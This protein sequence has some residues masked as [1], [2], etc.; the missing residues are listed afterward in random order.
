[1]QMDPIADTVLNIISKCVE[2]T[3]AGDLHQVSEKFQ[4]SDYDHCSICLNELFECTGEDGGVVSVR[5]MKCPGRHKFHSQCLRSWL[6]RSKLG[7]CPI[8]RH[9]FYDSVREDC[10]ANL[11]HQIQ[12]CPNASFKCIWSKTYNQRVSAVKIIEICK[13]S[14][15]LPFSETIASAFLWSLSEQC[16]N[17]DDLDDDDIS[18]LVLPHIWDALEVLAPQSGWAYCASLVKAFDFALSGAS[19]N[20]IL[21]GIRA[22]STNEDYVVTLVS[23]GCFS[24][25]INCLKMSH[26]DWD[27]QCHEDSYLTDM[28]A[29]AMYN[30]VLHEELGPV[31]LRELLEAFKVA[32]AEHER[33]RFAIAISE[34]AHTNCDVLDMAGC[35]AL[36]SGGAC[37]ALIED[38]K[39]S[40]TICNHASLNSKKMDEFCHDV[41]FAI[42]TLASS[43]DE[44]PAVVDAFVD[45]SACDALVAALR[46]FRM[47][48]DVQHATC[49]MTPACNV[50][51]AMNSISQQHIG[52]VALVAA[53]AVPELIDVLKKAGPIIAGYQ[54]AETP[55]FSFHWN[56]QIQE[57]AVILSHLVKT[58]KGRGELIKSD[59]CG[60]L[61]EILQNPGVSLHEENLCSIMHYVVC[62]SCVDDGRMINALVEGLHVASN[63][64]ARSKFSFVIGRL[65]RSSLDPNP[66]HFITSGSCCA[67]VQAF[68]MADDNGVRTDIVDAIYILLKNVRDSRA[69]LVAAGALGVLKESLEMGFCSSKVCAIADVIFVLSE[70]EKGPPPL[71]CVMHHTSSH[72]ITHLICSVS[73]DAFLVPA[74]SLVTSAQPRSMPRFLE[75]YA[76]LNAPGVVTS[77]PLSFNQ[78]KI[79][80][81]KRLDIEADDAVFTE[82]KQALKYAYVAVYT[83]V[84]RSDVSSSHWP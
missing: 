78:L 15:D 79:E 41:T 65:A 60:A 83:K 21:H 38:L 25:L 18:A 73:L 20:L 14:S 50:L 58:K 57:T 11:D 43:L 68:K 23:L 82:N 35:I 16:D 63:D 52:R 53:D 29:Y 55:D 30:F 9:N 24:I 62:I 36:I 10:E 13:S 3:I 81:A 22:V 64:Y 4:D 42:F 31:L 34:I 75:M 59:A 66:V 33:Q 74:E 7:D 46:I 56:E 47:N 1:M 61:I 37:T 49:D 54:I 51:N 6:A 67:L 76:A 70:P 2:A 44:C 80:I 39:K 77:N 32:D 45:A 72:I 12:P 71:Q 8:C 84:C 26:S 69:S 28:T 5:E 40:N 48:V 27:D 17:S 19:K